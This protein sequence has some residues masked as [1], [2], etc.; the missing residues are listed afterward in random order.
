MIS[1]FPRW[2]GQGV[3]EEIL[4]RRHPGPDPGSPRARA[5]DD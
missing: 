4:Q 3:E 2:R 5:G 1:A